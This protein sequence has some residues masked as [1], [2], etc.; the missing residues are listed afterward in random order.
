MPRWFR[1]EDL[2]GC[3][4]RRDAVHEEMNPVGA[5]IDGEDVI[6]IVKVLP[7]GER[8]R[9]GDSAATAVTGAVNG[10]LDRAGRA[11]LIFHDVDLAAVGPADG[12]DVGA[13]HPEG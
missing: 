8:V 6:G 4:W 11:A 12:A 13:E 9:G 1:R 2:R 10:A 5:P 3:A 7:A